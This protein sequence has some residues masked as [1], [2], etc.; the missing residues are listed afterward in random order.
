MN[1]KPEWTNDF[2][3]SLTKNAPSIEV[4][5]DGGRAIEIQSGVYYSRDSIKD[6]GW[7]RDLHLFVEIGMGD[8]M[9]HI[10]HLLETINTRV[11][12]SERGSYMM[13][14][15]WFGC[16]EDLAEG[17]MLR[18]FPKK[19]TR[20]VGPYQK[21]AVLT[22]SICNF[23]G[24]QPSSGHAWLPPCNRI[25]HEDLVIII[26]RGRIKLDQRWKGKYGKYRRHFFW[27]SPCDDDLKFN[28]GKEFEPECVDVEA[29][30]ACQRMNL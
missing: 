5:G 3:R 23:A 14:V 29:H 26:T 8:Y 21:M 25:G 4:P 30:A 9:S 2:L 16:F 19:N 22:E 15:Y 6:V 18:V 12:Y 11:R 27:F 28:N 24:N 1:N 10:T 7:Y 17:D 13:H 20:T